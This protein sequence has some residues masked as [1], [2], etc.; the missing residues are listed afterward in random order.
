MRKLVLSCSLVAISVTSAWTQTLFTYGSNEV[1]KKDFVRIYEK[2]SINKS[3]D[4]SEKA[5]QEYLDLYSLFRMKV[6]E[7][8]L[9][10]VDTMMSIQSELDNFRKQLAKNYFTDE[11]VNEQL[12]KEAYDRMQQDVRVAHILLMSSPMA[13]SKDTVAPYQKIDSIYNAV[14]KGGADFSAMAKK[15]SQDQGSAAAGGD[16]GYIT[17]LQTVYEFENAAYN[18]PVGKVSKPFR[19]RFGYHIVKVLDKR[20]A[21]GK[22]QVQ[23]I[24]LNTTASAGADAESKAKAEVKAIFAALKKG[25]SFDDLVDKYSD[26]KFSKS[27]NGILDPFGVG[28]MVPEFEKAAISLKKPGDVYPEA[29]KTDYGYHIIKLVKRETIKPYDS[30][31]E[32]IEKRVARDSRA[33]IAREVFFEGVKKKNNYKEYPANVDEVTQKLLQLPDTSA[34]GGNFTI[35]ALGTLNKPVFEINGQKYLQSDMMG[36]AVSITRGKIVGSKERFMNDLFKHY[37]RTV[38]QDVEEHNLVQDNP[39]F[40]AQMQEYRDGIM[41]FELMNNNVWGKAS[42][43][44]TG[45]ETFYK[46]NKQNYKWGAGYRGVVYKFKNEAAMKAGLKAMKKNSF[47]DE[48]VMKA[49]NNDKMPD[50]VTIERGYFEFAKDKRFSQ[51]E[52]VKGKPSTAKKNDDGSYLVAF[53]EDVFANGTTKTLD[54]ARGYVV[55]DYQDF[56]EKKWNK[57]LRA[58]YPVKVNDKVFKGLIK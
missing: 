45:L 41:L 46:N 48:D 56:L 39:E 17:A 15:Y 25:T 12:V 4:Y 26:D 58:K 2:N 8:E 1:D 19:T 16:M 33:D 51:S 36:Y 13:M 3:P 34:D 40:R 18:T 14:T 49:V 31:K 20:G 24:L 10:K 28:Q 47:T 37:S 42:K 27:N 22:V 54:E 29:I 21:I 9:Q 50:G 7:A 52:I 5:L 38:V 57:E 23:Q 53:A 55:A 30:L 32:N 11:K 44:T 35:D 6:K 43:D